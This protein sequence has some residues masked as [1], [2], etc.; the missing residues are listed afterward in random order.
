MHAHGAAHGDETGHGSRRRAGAGTGWPR[1]RR[2]TERGAPVAAMAGPERAGTLE[3]H[4]LEHDPGVPG[5]HGAVQGMRV[6]RYS[7]A[8]D[9]SGESGPLT[10]GPRPG[11]D[12]LADALGVTDLALVAHERLDLALDRGRRLDRHGD[13]AG[14]RAAP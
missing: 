12:P 10:A 1:S 5:T 3:G 13:S 4:V 11:Q 7:S 2:T 14:C 8:D 9:P 6:T